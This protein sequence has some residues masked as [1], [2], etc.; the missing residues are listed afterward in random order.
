M[1]ARPLRRLVVRGLL[2]TLGS[3][4]A[5]TLVAA[6]V[7]GVG[8]ELEV[9]DGGETIPLSGIAFVTGVFS[10]VG[11]VMA[12]ALLRWSA[13]PSDHFVR[14]AVALT[15]LS[16]LPPWLVGAAASTSAALVVLHL[17]AAVVMIPSLARSLPVSGP[18]GRAEHGGA[19]ARASLG[20]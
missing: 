9:P 20:A 7:T 2:A 14:T 19:P 18:S 6:L 10:L 16:L 11:V 5:T 17:V 15:A 8:V 4:V 13:R 12:A 1:S 3:V